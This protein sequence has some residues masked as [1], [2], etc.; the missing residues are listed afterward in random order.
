MDVTAIEK[1][2]AAMGF[3]HHSRIMSPF[4]HL[5]GNWID[6]GERP[7]VK[8]AV[9]EGRQQ[10]IGYQMGEQHQ[11]AVIRRSINH[12]EIDG[13]VKVGNGCLEGRQFLGL[14]LSQSGAFS[15]S[16]A[17]MDG[18]FE[19]NCPIICPDPSIFDVMRKASLIAV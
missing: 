4:G 13:L 10:C 6:R 12:Q 19:L 18:N 16:N 14:V 7:K 2:S 5:T 17:A 9:I 1:P 8:K 15:T 3:A 11:V